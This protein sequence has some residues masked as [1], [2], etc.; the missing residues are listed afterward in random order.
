MNIS[1]SLYV[2]RKKLWNGRTK[3]FGLRFRSE[4]SNFLGRVNIGD[5][6][7]I[8]AGSVVTKNVPAFTFAAGNPAKIIGKIEH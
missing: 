1:S 7:I 3:I 4:A 8:A 2:F 5:E 6:A